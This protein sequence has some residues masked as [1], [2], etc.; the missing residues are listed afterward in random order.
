MAWASRTR[1]R[2]E[3]VQCWTRRCTRPCLGTAARRPAPAVSVARTTGAGV[4]NWT[5]SSLSSLPALPA[6][7]ARLGARWRSGGITFSLGLLWEVRV[8]LWDV[9]TGVTACLLPTGWVSTGSRPPRGPP[10]TATGPAPSRNWRRCSAGGS[11]VWSADVARARPRSPER[12]SPQPSSRAMS[13]IRAKCS[14][15]ATVT[16]VVTPLRFLPTIRS[17]SPAC[18]LAG[19]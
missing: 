14:W 13:R 5:S 12:R 11:D 16:V 17:T 3:S 8:R 1:A 15:C 2:R 19:S 6:P 4:T 10:A 18:S 7:P 9:A